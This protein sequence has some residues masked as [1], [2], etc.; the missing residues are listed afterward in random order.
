[1]YIA[2]RNTKAR[3]LLALIPIIF[4]AIIYF[5]VI[6]PDQNTANKAVSQSEQQLNQQVQNDSAAPAN[7]KNLTACIAA[8]GTNVSAIEACKAK[9][10]N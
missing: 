2:V 1:M 9:F 5:T 7:V 6:K 8:A 10:Q 4:F 3:I